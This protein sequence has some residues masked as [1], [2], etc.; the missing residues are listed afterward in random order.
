MSASSKCI[1]AFHSKFHITIC[2]YSETFFLAH[3]NITEQISINVLLASCMHY[4]YGH[5]HWS[6][7]NSDMTKYRSRACVKHSENSFLVQYFDNQ[8]NRTNLIFFCHHKHFNINQDQSASNQLI[9]EI[10]WWFCSE[11]WGI[12]HRFSKPLMPDISL[13]FCRSLLCNCCH[14]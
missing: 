10:F 2:D 8:Q 4:F 11:G 9:A 7:A 5:S 12:K 6:V 14:K 13:R 1:Y 3:L